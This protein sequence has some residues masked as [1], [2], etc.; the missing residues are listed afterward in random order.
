[1]AAKRKPTKPS[2]RRKPTKNAKAAKKSAI[3]L[4]PNESR[5]LNPG[6]ATRTNTTVVFKRPSYRALKAVVRS[7][8]NNSSSEMVMIEGVNDSYYG[9]CAIELFVAL[10]PNGTGAALAERINEALAWRYG[11]D[12]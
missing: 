1:M 11:R 4:L 2:A 5:V 3:Q 8:T 6:D 12:G 7:P 10:V 9:P